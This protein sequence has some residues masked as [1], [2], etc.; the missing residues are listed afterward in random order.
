VTVLVPARGLVPNLIWWV[1]RYSVPPWLNSKVARMALAPL[2]T[3]PRP[4]VV[5]PGAHRRGIGDGVEDG[6]SAGPVVTGK[7]STAWPPEVVHVRPTVR[8]V[9]LAQEVLHRDW[10]TVV[11]RHVTQL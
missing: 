9:A 3:T 6:P 8:A 10:A 11:R 7:G 5:R 2:W 4:L 1:R